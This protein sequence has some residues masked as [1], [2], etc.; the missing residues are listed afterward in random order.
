MD[1]L[2]YA[3]LFLTES[4]EHV[5][6]VNQ[7]LLE[8]ERD[9]SGPGAASAVGA[10]FRAVHTI[11]G[12]GATM[13]Y[14]VVAEL[15]H[16]LETVLD[17][18]RSG[19][20]V[21]DGEVMDLL[22]RA[23]DVLEQAV[24]AAVA[25]REG[26]VIAT[27][28]VEALRATGEHRA[29]P[30]G[31][32]VPAPAGDGTLIRVRLAQNTPLRGVRAFIIV[33]SLGKM[34]EVVATEPALDDL[35]AE[36]FEFDFAVRLL[37]P[38][39]PADIEKSVR[40]A[41][42]VEDVQVG[43]DAAMPAR[44]QPVQVAPAADASHPEPR[45]PRPASRQVRIDVRRLDNLMNLVGELVIARG[46]LSQLAGDLGDAMLEET[47]NQSSRLIMELR[48]EITASRMVPVSQVFDRFPRIVRDAA[49][50]V[51]KQIE[52]RIE[53]KD[54]ELDRSMLDE[55]ADSLVHLLRNA[56]DHGIE[57]PAERAA[58]GKPE[59]GRLVLTAMRDRSAIVIKV[60]DDGKGIDRER[61][62]ARA[63]RDGLVDANK[64]ELTEDEL[65]RLLAR[66][67]FSTAEKV[68][69]LSGRGV[70]VD[71][72]YTKLRSLGGAMDIRSVPGQGTTMMLRLPLTLAIVRA[73]LARVD[74][75]TYAIPAAHV[76]E[77]VELTPDLLKTVKGRE[78]FLSRD[79]VLPLF[80]LR[81][82]V[83]MGPYVSMSEIDLEQVVVIDLGDR[84]AALV[85]DELTGQEEIVVKQYDAV[86]DGLPFFGGATLLGDGT[87][88]LI[89][90]VSSLL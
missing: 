44:P 84:R 79:E 41:G 15:A 8:L 40:N 82:L 22:F 52:F 81:K 34:G 51:G 7:A 53:G 14:A 27:E 36:G 33:A 30:G 56:I 76:S 4:R 55:I 48:D 64:T 90:D 1:N 87:P 57:S 13:G 83:D 38:S 77:T 60:S 11:K 66:P 85:I 10:I 26:E 3:E 72:V 37:T 17:R 24:E 16:E 18:V 80:R 46:R 49:R 62:L 58:K 20:L 2:Q 61:V 59:A 47:V 43:E 9:A 67:G 89:V 6:A 23:A 19:D 45:A 21:I 78:V 71:A 74:G 25:G 28:L 75:E 88:S 54:I 68:T 63:K 35:Q 29:V 5:T 12:M 86:H 69:D 39:S 50:A 32:T 73:L 70:G 31:W 65:L 42:D